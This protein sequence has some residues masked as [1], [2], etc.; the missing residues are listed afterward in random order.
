MQEYQYQYGDRPLEGYTIQ[1]AAGRG[2]FGEV[3]Y[4]VSDSGRE[5]ALKVIQ[6][7]EHIEV[8]GISQCMNLKSPHLV[9]IFDVKYNEQNKPFVIMEYVS[10][11]SLRELLTESPG[12]IGTQKAAFFLRE[13]AKGLSFLHECGIV[14]RDLKPSNIFYEGG[15]V[16]IG[17]YGLTKA[18]SASRHTGHTI[19]VGTVHYMAPEIGAG[20]YDRGVDIYTLGVLLY[21]MLTGQVPFMGS[22]PAEV[23]MKHMTAAPE[24]DNIEEPFARVIRKALSKD[25]A[26]RY[27]TVQEMV[28]DVFGAEHVRNSVSHFSPEELAIVAERVAKK[29]K[30]AEQDRGK[31]RDGTNDAAKHAADGGTPFVEAVRQLA[32]KADAFGRKVASKVDAKADGLFAGRAPGWRIMDAV[33]HRQRRTLGFVTTILVALGAGILGGRGGAPVMVTALAVFVMI[34]V[35]SET[36][37]FWRRRLFVNLE[38]ESQWIGKVAACCVAS[39]LT[40][41]VGTFCIRLFG[42]ETMPG[43]LFPFCDRLRS[44]DFRKMFWLGPVTRAIGS[45]GRMWLSLAIPMILVDWVRISA[46]T[47]PKRL[48]LGSAVWVGLLGLIAASI[49]DAG[50]LIIAAVLAGTSLLVQAV[51]PFGQ[52]VQV[53][54]RATQEQTRRHE[55]RAGTDS[56]WQ[57]RTEAILPFAKSLWLVGFFVALSAGLS[58]LVWAGTSEQGDEFGIGLALGIDGLILAAFC[59]M[60][61]GRRKFTTWYRYLI[62]PMVLLICLESVVTSAICLGYLNLREDQFVLAVMFIVFPAVAFFVVSFTGRGPLRTPAHQV[63]GAP[64]ATVHTRPPC[65]VGPVRAQQVSSFKRL[66]ALLLSAGGLLGF[67]GLHRFYVGKIGTGILWFLT[68]GLF[69]IGQVIDIIMIAVGQFKDRYGRPLVLWQEGTEADAKARGIGPKPD[70]VTDAKQE[71]PAGDKRAKTMDSPAPEARQVAP[72]PAIPTTTILYEPFHPLSFLMSGVGTALALVAILLGLALG[73][74]SPTVIDA[75]WPD[76]GLSADLEGFFGYSDWP[77]L[78]A[79]L[80]EV[81]III[82]LILAMLCVAIGRRHL[83]AAHMLRAVLGLGGILGAVLLFCGATHSDS[84]GEVAQMLKSNQIGPAFELAL[85]AFHT[86]KATFAGIFFGFSVLVLAWPARRGQNAYVALPNQGVS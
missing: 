20:N 19:T 69:W 80:G 84:F 2:G 53:S 68:G 63:P 8:R 10:G 55:H 34:A 76:A 16:K 3:Y 85:G 12:G 1:R 52:V 70:A 23:L 9:T 42:T 78:V 59:L 27:Q 33:D 36:L 65:A 47:R 24:L 40:A 35:C 73:L 5:V 18:I 11:P 75:G 37:L 43:E 64:R 28:E 6:N 25:P 74:Q 39:L 77:R 86:G 48:S 56:S 15:Y 26:D 71:P 13:I 58:F 61:A 82:L 67:C 57:K 29:A 45:P 4:A 51:S 41:F 32:D 46:P 81:V 38:A 79:Q 14:H 50:G 49:F 31:P 66:W 7:Y 17:D 72:S 30:A 21:E 22:S 54:P 83:G 44:L 62:K 60:M